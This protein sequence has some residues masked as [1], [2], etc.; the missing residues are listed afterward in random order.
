MCIMQSYA[1]LFCWKMTNPTNH[2]EGENQILN[3]IK[4]VEKKIKVF[5]EERSLREEEA[6]RAKNFFIQ[7]K[8]ETKLR[9]KSLLFKITF[10]LQVFWNSLIIHFCNVRC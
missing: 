1:P 2:E 3:K 9:I 8:N 6:R 4:E 7:R 5:L 10:D